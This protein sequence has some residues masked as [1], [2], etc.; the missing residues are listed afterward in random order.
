MADAIHSGNLPAHQ[1]QAELLSKMVV[2]A[3]V[4]LAIVRG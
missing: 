4:F 3:L 2:R 1:F